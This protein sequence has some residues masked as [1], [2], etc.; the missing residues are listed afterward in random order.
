MPDLIFPPGFVWG[1]ATSAY[2][3]EG[4]AQE[5]GRGESIWDRF[6]NTPG[7]V[8]D[9]SSGNVA[10][11]HYHRWPE[12]IELM[13]KLNLQ[14]YRF[15]VAWPRIIPDGR[16]VVNEAGLDHYD[17]FVDALLAADIEPFLTLYHWDLP[18]PLEDRGGWTE[19][20]SAEAFVEYA[21][22]VSGR[23]GDRVENWITH[24]EPW[25]ASM[26]GYQTGHH[27]PGIRD[28]SAAL[29]AS[30]HL[31]LSHGMSVSV[32]REN[33]R[34]AEVGITLNLVPAIAASDSEADRD[35]C[36][37]FDGYFNRWFLDPL[38]GR[39]YPA[40]MVSDYVDAG[41][42]PPEGLDFV[43]PADLDVIATT[44][45]FI[46]IN[47]YNREVVRSE[48]VPEA[49]NETRKVFVAPD[50]EHTDMGWEV[51]PDGL[52]EILTRVDQTYQPGKIY[53]T[54]NGASYGTR[55]DSTGR[56]HD[57]RRIQYLRDHLIAAHQAIEAGV[58]LAGYFAW[59]LLDNFEWAFGYAQRFGIT[60]VDYQTQQR[61]PKDSA[62]WYRDTI[63]H[64]GVEREPLKATA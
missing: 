2:Q 36:R 57:V 14:A 25:C 53:V 1:S 13:K 40:D 7:K 33:A 30:H 26:L 41:H 23:L 64:N 46:G 49:E 34:N 51:H 55:P 31:L 20:C 61:I 22:A 15:S 59:S 27:A 29:R 4:A 10:C 47:Y 5:D 60:W 9:G 12:D 24:N 18:Q 42:L 58:P 50:S 6:C 28:F 56:V 8:K 63:L 11:D 17:R 48:K 54:E 39:H 37:H 35:A 62:L 21:E 19:R 52:R 38:F 16:G 43:R 32:I 3:V 44:T 45:D